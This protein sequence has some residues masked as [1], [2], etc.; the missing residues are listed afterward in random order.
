M[1]KALPKASCR[2]LYSFVLR[3]EPTFFSAASGNGGLADGAFQ[4][5]NGFEGLLHVLVHPDLRVERHADR[6][7]FLD[8]ERDATLDQPERRRADAEC[9]ARAAAGIAEQHER[10][11]V[12]LG[13]ALVR[14]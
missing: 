9:L 11:A 5:V 1:R 14:R 12:V 10:Q 8:D 4:P 13:E 6:A 3:R 7:A 2:A